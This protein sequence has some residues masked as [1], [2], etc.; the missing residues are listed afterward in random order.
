[1]ND[2]STP[3]NSP[4]CTLALVSPRHISPTFCQSASVGWPLPT[5]GIFSIAERRSSAAKAVETFIAGPPTAAMAA[6]PAAPFST[7]RRLIM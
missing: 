5:P 7:F 2:S 1:M 6:T 4:G 3:L